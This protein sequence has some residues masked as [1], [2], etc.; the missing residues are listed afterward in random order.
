[1]QQAI[2]GPFAE[3]GI[4]DVLADDPGALLVVAAEEIAAV[5]IVS[6]VQL[7]PGGPRST[8]GNCMANGRR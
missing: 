6:R 7:R 2:G 3:G 8:I 5:V 1:M 4:L